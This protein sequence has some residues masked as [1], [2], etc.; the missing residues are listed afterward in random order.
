LVKNLIEESYELIDAIASGSEGAMLDE[1]GDLLLQ[2][3]F[4]SEIAEGFGVEDVAESL[5]QKL[6]RRHPHVFGS[7]VAPSSAEV[8][9]NWEEI[10]RA[11]R[12]R[13]PSSALEGVP[14]GMPALARAVKLGRNA[15]AV[16]FDWPHP[17]PVF[18]KIDEEIGELRAAVSAG[19]STA[20]EAELGDVLFTLVNLA[21]HLGIDPELALTRTLAEFS[22]R[23]QKME[24]SGS[25]DGL[26]PEELDAR[27]EAAKRTK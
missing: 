12:G 6:V 20:A 21:R 14:A 5:R 8:K 3:L 13:V 19:Q 27:W 4:H 17:G 9:A 16:G 25:L 15:A 10:K 7:V 24:E 23:F 26:S 11:E 18:E 22:R 1:L 2:V